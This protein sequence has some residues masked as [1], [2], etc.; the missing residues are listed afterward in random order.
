MTTN[1][2]EMIL[3]VIHGGHSELEMEM[4]GELFKGADCDEARFYSMLN[5]LEPRSNLTVVKTDR[6]GT[7][8]QACPE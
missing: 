5:G 3:D 8:D 4:I 2:Q 6:L 7:E 1:E